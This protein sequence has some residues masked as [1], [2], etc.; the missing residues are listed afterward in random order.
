MIG[1]HEDVSLIAIVL[2]RV[3]PPFN[4]F[5]GSAKRVKK[6]KESHEETR[7]GIATD[8]NGGCHICTSY[9]F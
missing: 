3:F 2:K 8:K 5:L 9:S 6:D 7:T 1:E 4:K